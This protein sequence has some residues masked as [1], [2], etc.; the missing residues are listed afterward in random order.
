MSVTP[1]DELKEFL[2][3]EL[4]TW[5]ESLLDNEKSGEWRVNFYMTFVA[6]VPA[7]VTIFGSDSNKLGFLNNPFVVSVILIPLNQLRSYLLEFWIQD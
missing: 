1:S 5:N 6:A 4:Q 2:L 7:A 3:Q